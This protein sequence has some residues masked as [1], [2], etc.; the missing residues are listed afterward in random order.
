MS[1]DQGPLACAV[2]GRT[3][4]KMMQAEIQEAAKQGA[5][6]IELRL[7]FLARAPD[8]K[9]LLYDRPCPIIATFRRQADGGRWTG[10]EEQRMMLIRQAIVA[11]FDYIDLEVDIIDK[12]PRFGKVKRIVSYHNV[13][14][15]P[16][17]LEQI[18]EQ[19]CEADADVFKIAVN[20][21]QTSD[22]LRV[23]A[24]LKNAK[25]P[26]VAMCMGDLGT[27]S[28][29]LGLRLGVPFAYGAF[30][31]ER[32]I[33][34]GILSYKE[35][36][37]VYAIER[38]N[39]ETKVFGVIGDP[40]GHSLSPLIH[41]AAFQDTNI[42]AMYVPFRV[43][44]GEL[45]AFLKS[46][47]EVPVQGYSITIPHKEA[48]AK[49]A[50]IVDAS[51][52]AMGAANTLTATPNGYSATNTDARAALDSLK[53]HLPND[54]EGKPMTL[55]SRTVMLVGAG[56][57]ARALAYALQQEKVNLVVTNRT[58]ERGR[59]LAEQFGGKF[60]EW[61]ARHSVTC[62]IVINCTSVGM[63]PNVDETP[64]HHSFLSPELMVF[65]TVYTPET[66][67]LIREARERGCPVLTG[68][69]MFVRQAAL[70]FELFTGQPAPFDL[71]TKRARKALSPVHYVDESQAGVAAMADVE[72]VA[73]EPV[74]PPPGDGEQ[75]MGTEAD[76]T[77]TVE[78]LPPPPEVADSMT[79]PRL[80]FLIGYRG[81]GKTSVAELLAARLGWSW[82]DADAT[83]E[84]R[85]GSSIRELFDS[86]GEDAF[87]QH[88]AALLD[89]FC[90]LDEHIIA[91]GGG[92][93]LSEE[94]RA[95]LG[96]GTVVWL[97]APAD[98]LWQRMQADP[99]TAQQ[100][101]DLAQGG[102]AEVEELL[103][104]RAPYYEACQH[105]TVDASQ[106][107]P[108]EI[109]AAIADWYRNNVLAT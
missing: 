3:R 59:Q 87:R 51:V 106:L 56:G 60:V 69:D 33:A 75:A 29:L 102:L 38:I 43:P 85:V 101:P 18:Y 89:E 8:F 107:S 37:N 15:V 46:F 39:A 99:A 83:L 1:T 19:M 25:K 63:H 34:P 16:E 10:T 12:I 17:Q 30:N 62:D 86:E 4:H 103:A 11:G 54:A 81:S 96:Q 13:Q 82:I 45:A 71:M 92:V 61:S 98:V 31:R 79:R 94:N 22:N 47:E 90:Q 105:V 40:I 68:V 104:A 84:Q 76:V 78:T 6:L 41:N 7:D 32:Q 95:R 70:Q 52:E 44:R 21:Q 93:I 20:A 108:S 73:S 72:T 36:Q 88:E 49:A 77:L 9:R 66:T 2:I 26:T 74:E 48:A 97:W 42:N 65:D 53:A 67:R 80:L 24:L 28:R 58:E 35:L 100:R 50:Q 27:C 91:T 55:A 64:I 14:Q 57:V 23:L 109:A 5:K